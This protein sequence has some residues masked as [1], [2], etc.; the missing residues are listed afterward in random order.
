MRVKTPGGL[1]CAPVASV[2]CW[3][4]VLPFEVVG[5][6]DDTGRLDL[7]AGGLGEAR[8]G[9]LQKVLWRR[10]SAVQTLVK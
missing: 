7:R 5:E 4:A 2:A 3:L 8:A 9:L 10:L 6:G 1:I